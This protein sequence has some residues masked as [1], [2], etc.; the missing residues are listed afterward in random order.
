MKTEIW[1]WLIYALP[2]ASYALGITRNRLKVPKEIRGLLA[3]RD[4]MDVIFRGIE[5][6]SAVS[7]KTDVEKR[8]YVRSWAKTELYRLLGDWLPDSA[9][10]YLIEHVIVKKKA[11]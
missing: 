6:A 5:A 8:E 2:I 7:G 4:V 3:N 9:V 1:Q 11:G 10:N